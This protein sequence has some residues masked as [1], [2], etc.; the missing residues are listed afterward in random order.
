MKKIIVV[1][2]SIILCFGLAACGGNSDNPEKT[3]N[4]ITAKKL[5]FWIAT[6]F[7]IC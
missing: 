1:I 6:I 4:N 5:T 7:N 2:V 3:D